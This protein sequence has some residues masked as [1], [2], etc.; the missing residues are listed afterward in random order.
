[1]R[2]RKRCAAAGF[3]AGRDACDACDA[4]DNAGRDAGCA[5]GPIGA[6]G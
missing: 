2:D 6:A 3:A 4:C 5:A 1:V